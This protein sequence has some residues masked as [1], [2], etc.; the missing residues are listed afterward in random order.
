MR[1]GASARS[2][3][4]TGRIT[5]RRRPTFVTAG[6]APS[7]I[8]RLSVE[9]GGRPTERAIV[10][11]MILVSAT[12][13]LKRN[14]S[15]RKEGARVC[16]L[17]KAGGVDDAAARLRLFARGLTDRLTVRTGRQSRRSVCLP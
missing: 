4:P 3:L 11:S 2:A 10:I 1:H 15:P 16:H 5:R 6:N 8:R 9:W 12:G 17:L 13:V 14:P 7:A